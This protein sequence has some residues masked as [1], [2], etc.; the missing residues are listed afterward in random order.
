MRSNHTPQWK[1]PV[2]GQH[3]VGFA[4]D[5]YTGLNNG[6]D[7]QYQDDPPP[8]GMYMSQN[9]VKAHDV[10]VSRFQTKDT[11]PGMHLKQRNPKTSTF[12]STNMVKDANIN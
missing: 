10:I 2:S 11:F 6:N 12:A 5:L 4:P 3:I 8:T 7:D 9:F 1:F